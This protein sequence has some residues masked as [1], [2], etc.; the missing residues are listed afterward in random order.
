MKLGVSDL[1]KEYKKPNLETTRRK[2]ILQERLKSFLQK[3]GDDSEFLGVDGSTKIANNKI[4]GRDNGSTKTRINGPDRND[5]DCT[6]RRSGSSTIKKAAQGEQISAQEI[7]SQ[8]EG[9]SPA[10]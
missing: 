9:M 10:N 3:S 4:E 1:K 8:L 2:S 5:S 6:M 7:I